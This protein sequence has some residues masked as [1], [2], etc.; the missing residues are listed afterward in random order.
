MPLALNISYQVLPLALLVA[1]KT[2]GESIYAGVDRREKGLV[3]VRGRQES[4]KLLN[5]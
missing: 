4:G 3:R 5:K 1:L 2:V